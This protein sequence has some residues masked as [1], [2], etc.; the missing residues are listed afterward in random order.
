MHVTPL[1]QKTPC[2]GHVGLDLSRAQNRHTACRDMDE[3]HINEMKQV[4]DSPSRGMSC[5][6]KAFKSLGY[7]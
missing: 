4:P 5:R 6:F 2:V 3:F 7:L 1:G